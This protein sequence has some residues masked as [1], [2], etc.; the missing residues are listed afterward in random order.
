MMI[1]D[2]RLK[3]ASDGD[4][5]FSI[6]NRQSKIGNQRARRRF[7]ILD[8]L[9]LR[10]FRLGLD[11]ANVELPTRRTDH[12]LVGWVVSSVPISPPAIQMS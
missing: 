6:G 3:T 5:G 9:N 8:C 2:C 10:G 7:L 11:I 1:D 4:R 12:S